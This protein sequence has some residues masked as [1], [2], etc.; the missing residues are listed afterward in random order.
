VSELT[1]H[2][3]SSKNIGHACF[4][5]DPDIK[6]RKRNIMNSMGAF[7]TPIAVILALCVPIYVYHDILEEHKIT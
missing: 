3:A 2:I 7:R 4:T 1:K 6:V 5:I